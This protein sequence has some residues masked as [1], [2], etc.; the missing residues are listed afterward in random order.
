MRERKRKGKV[1]PEIEDKIIELYR[2]GMMVKDIATELSLS[3]N[4]I[5][6]HLRYVSK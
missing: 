2:A 6:T 4:T 5:S 1:T 3:S